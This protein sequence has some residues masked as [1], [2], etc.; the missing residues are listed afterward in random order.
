MKQSKRFYTLAA[1]TPLLTS[2]ASRPIELSTVGPGPTAYLASSPGKG[3]LKVFTQTEEYYE[4]EM[5][6]FPHTDYQIYTLDGKRLKLVWNHQTHED[7]DPAVVSLPPGEYKVKAWAECY[8]AVTV[9][10]LIRTNQTTRVILQ[11]GWKPEQTVR[12]SDLVQMPNGYFV[13]WRAEMLG[14]K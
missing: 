10:V 12:S 8:G 4:D 1:I 13:G 2:C 14:K 11:P 9:P 6:Y 7:P 5:S 3:D